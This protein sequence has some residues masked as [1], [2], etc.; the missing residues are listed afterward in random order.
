MQQFVSITGASRSVALRF[1][2]ATG[3]DTQEAVEKF[4][5]EAPGA[6][7]PASAAGPSSGK[8]SGGSR[9]TGTIRSLGDLQEGEESEEDDDF[10]DYYVGGEKS[11]QLVR[12]APKP[13][14]GGDAVEDI[15][16]SA[17]RS[18]AVQGR[19]EDLQSGRGGFQSFAGRGRTLAGGEVAPPPLEASAP[20]ERTVTIAFYANGIFTI[21][22]GEPRRMD[23]P[24]NMAFVAA[25]SR[26]HC[27]PELD[28]GDPN[29]HIRINMVRHMGD[30]EP[31]AQPKF[32]A[33]A[34]S[35]HK[36]TSSSAGASTS[37]AAAPPP[38][39]AAASGVPWEGADQSKPKTSIQLRLGDGSRVVAEFNLDHT[40]GDIRRFIRAVRPD[41]PAA[42]TLATAFPPK[43]LSDDAATVEASGLA[44]S[45]VI[46]KM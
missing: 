35:G 19:P 3:G 9:R 25:I 8:R 45:V 39:A 37:G 17:R 11:G 34:G 20:E 22:D 38:S 29:V 23:D 44:N 14:E 36:L 10:N 27:P 21:D 13:D 46:Q 5:A 33:F 16:E 12:G 31:P 43:Q 41:M 18:G 15:F 24:A 1:L 2:D 6:L 26:G 30:Y 4:Y 32:K 42:Y 40:V 28:P 7:A